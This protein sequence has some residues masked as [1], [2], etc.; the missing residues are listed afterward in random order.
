MRLLANAL[1]ANRISA[2]AT[3]D[4]LANALRANRISA[5]A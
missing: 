1:R 5:E 2:E 4:L 3:L